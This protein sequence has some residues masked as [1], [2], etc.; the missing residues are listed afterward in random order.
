MNV[1]YWAAYILL[2]FVGLFAVIALVL[3][4]GTLLGIVFNLLMDAIFYGVPHLD[5]MGYTQIEEDEE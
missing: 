4:V 3:I 2:C 5:H 1:M